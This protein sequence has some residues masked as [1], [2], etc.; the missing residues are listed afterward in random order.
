MPLTPLPNLQGLPLTK[1]Q[2]LQVRLFILAAVSGFWGRPLFLPFPAGH[3]T[4][5]Y[6]SSL[7]PREAYQLTTVAE[8][9]L[10][11]DS[12][13]HRALLPAGDSYG[14]AEGEEGNISILIFKGLL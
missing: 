8:E 7:F 12:L 1:S 3:F 14:I 6:V 4:A 11:R 5:K 2:S 9:G 13:G 10:A